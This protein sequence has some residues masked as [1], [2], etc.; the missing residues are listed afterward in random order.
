MS[1][2][3]AGCLRA[4]QDAASVPAPVDLQTPLRVGQ[5]QGDG[6]EEAG[7]AGAVGVILGAEAG[8]GDEGLRDDRNGV[9]CEAGDVEGLD[10]DELTVADN[11]PGRAGRGRSGH[12]VSCTSWSGAAAG[13][14]ARRARRRQID[15]ARGLPGSASRINCSNSCAAVD[16]LQQFQYL[17]MFAQDIRTSALGRI[18]DSFPGR[19]RTVLHHGLSAPD[20]LTSLFPHPQPDDRT[21]TVLRLLARVGDQSS[22]TCSPCIA[23]TLSSA[24]QPQTPFDVSTTALLKANCAASTMRSHC[25]LGQA[26]QRSLALPHL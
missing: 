4:E 10:S 15:S 7:L 11:A 5:Q 18:V 19:I 16:P 22:S 14:T 23:T 20:R 9:C 24:V 1:L 3:D 17:A 26:E 21:A 12:D 8:D 6:D 2:V 25:L 13:G